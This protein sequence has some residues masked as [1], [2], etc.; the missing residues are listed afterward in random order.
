MLDEFLARFYQTI[1]F[2]PGKPFP[3]GDFRALFRP[4]AL[5]LEWAES[6]YASKTVEEHIREFET[7]VRD[8]PELFAE[9]FAERQTA[10]EWT[11]QNGVYLVHSGYE[12][13]YMRGGQPVAECGV[14][15]F[16]ILVDRGTPYIACAVWE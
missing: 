12:K 11:E 14:N 8:Y 5:L 13:R 4:D 7:V 6:G 9:G 3:A 10:L 1:S 16:T 2:G 15:H